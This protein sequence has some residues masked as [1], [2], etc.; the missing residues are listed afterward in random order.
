ME[1]LQL[2]NE[3]YHAD[4]SR[5][6]NSGL[7]V[8]GR[9][10]AHYFA[11]Y[12][13]PDRQ[14]TKETPALIMGSAVHCAILEPDQFNA[15][16]CG[17]FQGERR[18]N[19]GK[20]AY[21]KFREDNSGRIELDQDQFDTITGI[22]KAVRG[23]A[24]ANRLL[25]LAAGQVEGVLHFDKVAH[26]EQGP[27][28]VACKIRM[29][30]LRNSNE[31]I[32]DI[33]TTEDASPSEFARSVVK[34]G[35]HR[36]AAFYLDAFAYLG[37]EPPKR[38]VFVA[39]EKSPPYALA[40]YYLPT[41]AIEIGRGIYEENLAAYAKAVVTGVWEGYPQKPQALTLPAWALNK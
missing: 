4:T 13:A 1:L 37:I 20:A 16:Y 3:E 35:Y 28:A 2:T 31:F 21:A 6:S 36:Q 17:A 14:P 15:R 22:T 26:L 40:V 30:Y 5:I 23:H 34:Y 11:K 12:L 33:K 19:E 29:D 7:A 38:F 10:P 32:A 41:E 27:V 18:T 24:V 25:D 9:S 8:V 39:V